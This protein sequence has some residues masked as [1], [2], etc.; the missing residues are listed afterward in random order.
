[1][2]LWTGFWAIGK[3]STIWAIA[4]HVFACTCYKHNT[5][6]RVFD[7]ISHPLKSFLPTDEMWTKSIALQCNCHWIR[8][9]F[10]G[11]QLI[12][13]LTGN[14]VYFIWNLTQ[15]NTGGNTVCS[16][17]NNYQIKRIFFC[18]VEPFSKYNLIMDQLEV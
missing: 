12:A 18:I 3:W 5:L 6:E 11:L 13:P 16:W 10:E 15:F 1:M 8:W 14:F 7:Y 2:I 4:Q 9:C 17:F